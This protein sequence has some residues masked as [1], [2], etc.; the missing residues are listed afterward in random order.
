MRRARA[1]V[2]RVGVAAGAWTA[3][4][5]AAL[6][7]TTVRVAAVGT[8]V[9]A[10]S[11]TG[12]LAA[13]P[14]NTP[15]DAPSK[16]PAAAPAAAPDG[17]SAVAQAAP[18][19]A[20][21][22]VDQAER[23][24]DPARV[25]EL[26]ITFETPDWQSLLARNHRQGEVD[27]PARLEV[28]G[29]VLER[30]GVRYK[31]NTSLDVDGP[32]K[33]FNLSIDAFV[34]G[35]RLLGYDVVNLNNGWG[36]PSALREFSAYA[37]LADFMPMPQ[38]AF[39]R[40][41]VNDRY[42]GAYLMVEQIERSFLETWF[43]DA[44]GLLFKADNPVDTQLESST[45]EH[46]ATLDAYRR[47]YELK[48]AATDEAAAFGRLQ[49]L[50]RAL[51]A[52]PRQG[53]IADAD[54]EPA[55]RELLDVDA[56][57]W[58]LAANNALMNY[59]SYYAGHNYY[60]YR[61]AREGRFALLNWDW[62]LSFGTFQGWFGGLI[63]REPPPAPR[64]EPLDQA[65]RGDRPLTRRL[66]GVPAY[67]A[68][69]LAHLRTLRDRLLASGALAGLATAGQDRLREAVREERDGLYPFEQFER[70][71]RSE[72]VEEQRFGDRVVHTVI[73]G[74]LDSAEARQ[75]FLSDP[76]LQP[77]LVTPDLRLAGQ[78]IDP[79]EPKQGE[80][81]QVAARFEG[82]DAPVTVELRYRLA[83][84]PERRLPMQAS[85]DGVWRAEIP[86]QLPGS[87]LGY[88]LRAA[89]AEGRVVFF[90]E[91]NLTRPY[92]FRVAGL[93]LPERLGGPL[94]INE[95]LAANGS[96]GADAGGDF[97]D[98]VELY[99]RGSEPIDLGAYF[100][101][102]RVDLPWAMALPDRRLAPGERLLIWCD[103][104]PEEGPDHAPFRLSRSGE[105][106]VLAS[107]EAIVDRVDFGPQSEDRS[108]GRSLDGAV[109]WRVCDRP[110][111]GRAN[112]CRRRDWP[113]WL[114][115]LGRGVLSSAAAPGP[116]RPG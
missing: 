5:L 90:P 94:V 57:L 113:I 44:G 55:I 25:R 34:P 107:R 77:D 80:P 67:R 8:L 31:G 27:A 62:N 111:P 63:A 10:T 48:R 51:D 60:L 30:V 26:R 39:A 114:P 7:R 99:N 53:G 93:R 17:Y 109:D 59:D 11:L 112:D 21:A 95:L 69:Y 42:L 12:V 74:L 72:V 54:F 13:Q 103:N 85:A 73:P 81:V 104:A 88:A 19:D 28:D 32:K 2:G 24:F 64:S 105:R 6:G 52:S 97:E 35:Q 61:G 38:A 110:T 102:D 98:W 96:N 65:E 75:A 91:A 40:V 29:R 49:D 1:G 79:A 56:A 83:G 82:L 41:W 108:W 36:D 47:G 101:S 3:V 58:Y 76:A 116:S 15:R 33:P 92:R 16:T 45:L 70:N 4:G 66:L 37:L 22:V 86:P 50:T 78:G 18:P 84:G 89:T 9:L 20:N 115:R 87:E 71:L 43:P 23:L 14:P 100:L 46:F 106:L 68:D